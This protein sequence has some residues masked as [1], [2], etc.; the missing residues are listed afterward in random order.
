MVPY[1]GLPLKTMKNLQLDQNA[2]AWIIIG[3]AWYAHVIC[4][5]HCFSVCIWVWFKVPIVPYK[6]LNGI[7]SGYLKDCLS[8]MTS[9]WTF[10]FCLV[11]ILRGPLIKQCHLSRP[12]KQHPLEQH[13]LWDLTLL[14]FIWAMKISLFSSPGLWWG[15]ETF[16]FIVLDIVHWYFFMFYWYYFNFC[17][18]LL[19]PSRTLVEFLHEEASENWG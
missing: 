17:V 19:W 14:L 8:S 3:M 12:W 4:K 5:L 18:W 13:F 2:V 9:D 6:A 16:C 15:S 7:R 11:V 1:L 10:W